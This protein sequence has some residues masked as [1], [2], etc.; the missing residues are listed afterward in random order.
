[1]HPLWWTLAVWCGQGRGTEPFVVGPLG[2]GPIALRVHPPSQGVTRLPVLGHALRVCVCGSTLF[3]TA[4][5]VGSCKLAAFLLPER[6]SS[7]SVAAMCGTVAQLDRATFEQC[8]M[9]AGP[10]GTPPRPGPHWFSTI[11]RDDNGDGSGKN[12][13]GT[14]AGTP[15][16]AGTPEAGE[17]AALAWLATPPRASLQPPSFPSSFAPPCFHCVQVLRRPPSA[18]GCWPGPHCS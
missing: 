16:P 18:L 9:P 1:V 15:A 3:L 8:G 13:K 7:D 4:R 10:P 11:V 5:R 12:V 2:G 14:K 6:P 17:S